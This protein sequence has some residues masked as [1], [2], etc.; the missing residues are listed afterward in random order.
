[1]TSPSST[2]TVSSPSFTNGTVTYQISSADSISLQVNTTAQSYLSLLENSYI[3]VSPTLTWSSL[4]STTIVF[5]IASYN[6]VPAPVWV[7][8]DSSSGLLKITT[9]NATN[10]TSYSFYINAQVSSA[11][12]TIQKLITINVA[13]WSSQNCKTWTVEDSTKWSSCNTNYYLTSGSCSNEATSN[14]K[15]LSTTTNSLIGGTAALV[16]LS[17]TINSSSFAS[18]WA[19][20]NQLQMFLLILLTRAY[21]PLDIINFII[22]SKITMSLYDC[23]SFKKTSYSHP[24]IDLFDFDQED[25]VLSK[26]GLNSGS[27]FVNNYSLLNSLIL[28]V[29]FHLVV[30]A[31]TF[32]LNKCNVEGKWAKPFNGIKWIVNK[33]FTILTFG[34]YIR[35]MIETYQFMLISSI[36]E[37]NNNNTNSTEHTS[38]LAFAFLILIVW[39]SYLGCSFFLVF[40]STPKVDNKHNK[41]GEFFDGLKHGIWARLYTFIFLTRRLIFIALLITLAQKCSLVIIWV[42]SFLQ[43]TYFVVISLIRPFEQIKDNLI[44]I[45]NEVFF[46]YFICWLIP[47]KSEKDWNESKTDTY[48]SF[49][50]VLLI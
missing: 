31:F 37:I 46:L 1:M 7:S 15:A 13:K 30:F 44:E 11:T 35:T 9:Q 8:I 5:S 4:S 26:I 48:Y 45:I 18:L 34:Y 16:L 47:F 41:L 22:G 3:E 19:I 23:I 39:I 10:L 20:M 6:G 27:T 14:V 42:I 21:L 33:A 2:A 28:M 32:W 29:L 43:L 24:I 25:E 36:S 50:K 12:N 17:S 38:S 40:V 49:I